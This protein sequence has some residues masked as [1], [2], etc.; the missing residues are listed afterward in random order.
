M[1]DQTVAAANSPG[2]EPAVPWLVV[3]LPRHRGGR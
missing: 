2:L 1:K 3:E